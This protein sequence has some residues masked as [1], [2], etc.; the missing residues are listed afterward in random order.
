MQGRLAWGIAAIAMAVVCTT[1][2]RNAALRPTTPPPTDVELVVVDA[3][4]LPPDPPKAPPF[5]LT[6]SEGVGLR[7][8]SV[9]AQTVVEDPLALTELH[10]V[11]E[12]P[13]PR[14]IE[15]R[16][17]LSLPPGASLGRFAMRIG[18]VLQE[19]E[20]VEKQAARLTYEEYLHV[21]RDPALLEQG[22]A[23]EVAVRVFPIEA[24]EKKEIVVTYS[25]TLDGAHPYRLRLVGLPKIE[26]LDAAAF[27]GGQMV[28]A[29]VATNT[30]PKRDLLVPT[31]NWKVAH[32]SAVAGGRDVALRVP[33]PGTS[34]EEPATDAVFALI[35]TS[36]SRGLDLSGEIEA[37]ALRARALPSSTR[38]VVGAYDQDVETIFDG[39]AGDFDDAAMKK[40]GA[41]HALGATD[42]AAA[43]RWATT[44]PR[45]TSTESRRLFVFG[46]GIA[47]A[48][49]QTT[50]ELATLAHA[51]GDVGFVRA[52]ALVL[53]GL[54]DD[55]T[56]QALVR[57]ALPHAGVVVGLDEDEAVIARR[58]STMAIDP[59]SVTVAGA[60]FIDP[61]QIVGALPGDDVVIHATFP[62]AAPGSAAVSIGSTKTK[63]T[64][65]AAPA[66][67][68]A[69]SVAAAR[70]A[71]LERD[72]ALSESDKKSAIVALAIKNRVESSYTGMLVLENDEAYARHHID[73]KSKLDILTVSHGAVTISTANRD[74]AREAEDAK[75]VVDPSRVTPPPPPE[76]PAPEPSPSPQSS[77]H[78]VTRPPQVRMGATMVSGRLPPEVV[79]RIVRLSFGRFRGCYQAALLGHPGLTGRIVVRFVIGRDGSV[80]S[81]SGDSDLPAAVREC[82]V[83]GFAALSFPEPEGGLVS[84]MYPLVFTPDGTTPQPV[85][86]GVT[87]RPHYPTY[88]RYQAPDY[89]TDPLQR[90]AG[91]LYEGRFG[92]I[93]ALVD[94]RRPADAVRAA[95]ELEAGEPTNVLSFVAL[96][97]A[98]TAAHDDAL[99]ARAYGSILELW[100]YRVDMRRFAGELLDDVGHG[101]GL[102]LAADAYDGA[103][104]DRPDHPSSH[105]LLAMNLLRRDR[106][107]AAFA[108]LERGVQ[109]DYAMG[110][111]AGATRLL[112]DDLATVGAVWA[113]RSPTHVDEIRSRLAKYDREIDT[114]PAIRMSLVWESDANDVDLYVT[115]A[116]G[117]HAWYGHQT[118]SSGGSFYADVTTGY[119]PEGFLAPLTD[120]AMQSYRLRVHYFAR[121]AMGFGMGKVVVM[122]HDG[123]GHVAFDDRPF[124]LMTRDAIVDLGTFRAAALPGLRAD[125]ASNP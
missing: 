6:S 78:H 13:E 12:N 55:D 118:L 74:A 106:P 84:V 7:I 65:R 29:I 47:T 61:M 34:A 92:D 59:V 40:I 101:R 8:A 3:P 91:P 81:A 103:A 94:A 119:G 46:D 109:R 35:D 90:V 112:R 122:T 30:V 23:N 38:L 73:R 98:A 70:I 14:R 39:S 4:P 115:D 25:E 11:F 124:V 68:V 113:A 9:K 21:R 88:Q 79:Q 108:A 76:P 51:L 96:G 125:F 67:L 121:G 52:D 10:L 123:H 71:R 18:G 54:R 72:P 87:P 43:L 95:W 15:G 50:A 26:K 36:A 62:G 100:S 82:V 16:F 80:T 99:A 32:V 58:L 28:A 110:Q 19:G 120:P 60:S 56:L 107:D 93:M 64:T 41:R 48:G 83:R 49:A 5:Q 66:P 31:Q 22:A 27:V 57:G 97:R 45:A 75:N 53:G 44:I 24:G 2:G 1:C 69:R 86:V 17:T 104:T 117:E 114:K 63:V 105:W 111:F 89:N 102:V 116:A 42:Y 77:A 37:L 33:V 85:S 20:V